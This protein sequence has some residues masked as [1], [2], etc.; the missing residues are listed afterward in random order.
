MCA[1][2]LSKWEEQLAQQIMLDEGEMH[3]GLVEKIENERVGS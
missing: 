1:S 2:F 3:S